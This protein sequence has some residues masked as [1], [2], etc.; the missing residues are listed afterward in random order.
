MAIEAIV[1]LF[2]S[3]SERFADLILAP[4]NFREVLWMG[5][6]LLVTIVL[7]ELYFGR[8]TG[9]ELGWESAFG[10]SLVLIFVCLDMARFL[11]NEAGFGAF[12]YINSKIALIIAVFIEGIILSLVAFY[13]ILPEN[14]AFKFSSAFPMNFIA[15]ISLLLVYT[16]IPFDIYTILSAFGILAILVGIL[17]AVKYIEPKYYSGNIKAPSPRA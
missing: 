7:I 16:D 4:A 10:N 5:I 13:R 15:Y 17:S 1:N 11:Y 3:L 9:E 8:Y 14:I 2:M 6:P 12:L